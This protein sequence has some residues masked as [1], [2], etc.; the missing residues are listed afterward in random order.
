MDGGIILQVLSRS[1]WNSYL[2]EVKLN[3]FL[4]A[5]KIYRAKCACVT[6]CYVMCTGITDTYT[7]VIC[8][9]V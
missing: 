1:E 5:P 6:V 9:S 2:C 8:S 4:Q 3:A 7:H